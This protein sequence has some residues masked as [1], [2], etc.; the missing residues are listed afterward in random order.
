MAKISWD[1][2]IPY[3]HLVLQTHFS[4]HIMSKSI[5]VVKKIRRVNLSSDLYYSAYRM[6]NSIDNINIRENFL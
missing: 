5:D 4:Y 3:N 2:I 6:F 1:M